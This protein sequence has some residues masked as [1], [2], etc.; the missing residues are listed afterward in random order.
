MN[1]PTLKLVPRHETIDEATIRAAAMLDQ[2]REYIRGMRQ[3]VALFSGAP[4]TPE[5]NDAMQVALQAAAATMRA[6]TPPKVQAQLDEL[7]D[8]LTRELLARNHV[9]LEG[10]H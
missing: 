1:P 9:Q 8:E 6:V 2:A 7:A 5:Q 10:G 3:G 4:S